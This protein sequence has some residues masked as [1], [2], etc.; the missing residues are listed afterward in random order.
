MN[1][2]DFLKS[3]AALATVAVAGKAIGKAVEPEPVVLKAEPIGDIQPE[4]TLRYVRETD[5][6]FYQP[7]YPDHI[8]AQWPPWRD[9]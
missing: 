3:T 9:K 2:R 4:G 6:P 8:I 7:L 5:G 1:R